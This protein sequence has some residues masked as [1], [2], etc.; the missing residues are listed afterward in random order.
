MH[1]SSVPD[2]LTPSRVATMQRWRQVT[3]PFFLLLLSSIPPPTH[4]DRPSDRPTEAAA[5]S[6]LSLRVEKKN[7]NF[8]N[9]KRGSS[10]ASRRV[11]G[12]IFSVESQL[13]S[14]FLKMN[15]KTELICEKKKSRV[16]LR[17]LPQYTDCSRSYSLV[18][19]CTQLKLRPHRRSSLKFISSFLLPLWKK[20]NM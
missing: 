16:R 19:F 9:L 2:A 10:F 12:E 1:S 4:I 15:K 3:R 17:P 5:A 8:L 11:V 13:F 6:L 18:L 7:V 14:P 20:K